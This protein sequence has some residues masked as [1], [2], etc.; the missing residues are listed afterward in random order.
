MYPK[1]YNNGIMTE[2]KSWDL[3]GPFHLPLN[4]ELLQFHGWKEGGGGRRDPARNSVGN[5][6]ITGKSRAVDF[7]I[8]RWDCTK[9]TVPKDSLQLVGVLNMGTSAK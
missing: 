3:Q 9:E 1:W 2:A 8:N 4:L 5:I 6:I 7:N